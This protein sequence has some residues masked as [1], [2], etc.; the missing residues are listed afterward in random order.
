MS[1]LA[2]STGH[3]HGATPCAWCGN[4]CGQCSDDTDAR[5]VWPPGHNAFC[6]CAGAPYCGT[7]QHGT[8]AFCTTHTSAPARGTHLVCEQC[9][10]AEDTELTVPWEDE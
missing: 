5:Y 1:N 7:C 4:L 3:A 6:G 9:L 10:G 2:S 8:P